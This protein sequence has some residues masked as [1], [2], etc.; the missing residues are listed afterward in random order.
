M[1]PPDKE[2]QAA[3]QFPPK[4]EDAWA[5]L[6]KDHPWVAKDEYYK[7]NPVYS[8]TYRAW[9]A[10]W[11]ARDTEVEKLQTALREIAKAKCPNCSEYA[12]EALGL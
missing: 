5:Y 12:R 1:N 10:G 2:A 11:N 6:V 7:R 3:A 9:I 4:N 8:M